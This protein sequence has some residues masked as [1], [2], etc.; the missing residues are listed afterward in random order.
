MT[1]R[2]GASLFRLMRL[3]L[4]FSLL[5]F[6]LPSLCRAIEVSTGFLIGPKYDPHAFYVRANDTEEWRKTNSS[7]AYRK[8]AQGKLVGVSAS[9]GTPLGGLR[10]PGVSLISIPLQGSEGNSFREDGTM[11]P[12]RQREIDSLI[13]A[14]NRSGLI[15]EI[16][17][18]D[19]AHDHDFFS[20]EQIL[21]AARNVTDWLI[22]RNHR[23]VILSFAADWTAPG[24][25][26]DNFVP[27]HLE[28]LAETVR[29]RFQARRTDYVLPIAIS[30]KVRL[31]ADSPLINASDLLMLG[32]EALGID[33]S[34]IERPALVVE[35]RE[36][37]KAFRRS[38]GC[39]VES[40]ASV[41]LLTPLLF[42]RPAAVG[43]GAQ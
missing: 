43:A 34:E 41:G 29:A 32:G 17:L 31:S 28:Q 24:W 39:V 36:C 14:A 25:D 22:D 38:S 33:I 15:V 16:M 26:F 23:N 1:V 19:P 37:V 20:P 27:L 9:A 5:A 4:C 21:S 7:S 30:V 40:P 18:F 2:P 10:A 12:D 3:F 11:R 6:F 13:Q 8:D 42:N 35:E